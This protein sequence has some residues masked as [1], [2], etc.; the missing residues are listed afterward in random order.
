MLPHPL[1]ATALKYIFAKMTAIHNFQIG[2]W[3]RQFLTELFQVL[4]RMRGRV[5]FTNMARYSAFSEQTFRRHFQKAFRWVTLN[6]TILR[7]RRHPKEALIGVFD[8][9]FVPKSGTESYGLGRFFSSAAGRTERG[10]EVSILGVVATKS[11]EAF[12][13]DATQTPAGLCSGTSAKERSSEERSSEERSAKAY[14]AKAYSSV[15]FYIEQMQDLHGPL[16]EMGVSYWVGDGFY[17]KRKVFEAITEMGGDLITRLR[18][19]ANLRYLYTGPRKTGPGAP[20]RYDGKITF[21]RAD[22]IEDR[23]EE[24]GRLPDRTHVEIWTTVA[25]SPHFK[26]NLRIVLLRNRKTGHVLLLCSTDTEQEA[27]EVVRYYR[28]RYQIEF[29]IRDAKQHTGLTH[30]QA[31]SQE[32]IDFHLNMSVAGVNLLR[33]MAG[34]AGC[35]LRTYRILAYNRFL[36]GRL[37]SELGLSGEWSLSDREVQPVL[38]TGQMAT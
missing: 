31:Q 19:D 34:K 38:E 9:T 22:Q 1:L 16:A 13:I 35:S 21:D 14:S 36:A 29:V 17:A 7:L 8:C 33:L 37:F 30:C 3:Q 32:K 25:N 2:A 11:R 4:L 10:Q 20:K 24:I 18:S 12:G 28:L 15:D 27:E 6:L 26:R 5:N 23:F